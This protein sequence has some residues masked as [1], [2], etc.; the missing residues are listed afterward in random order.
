MA[1]PCVAV[2]CRAAGMHFVAAAAAAA[3]HAAPLDAAGLASARH[4]QGQTHTYISGN[5]H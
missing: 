4:T 5:A 2:A 3:A 1:Q